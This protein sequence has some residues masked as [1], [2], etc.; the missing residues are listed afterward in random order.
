MITQAPHL[1]TAF[2]AGVLSFLTPC[3][4]PLVPGY[5]SFI[6]GQ[7]LKDM[8]SH[9]HKRE[10]LYPVMV[11]TLSF[12]LGFSLVFVSLGAAATSLGHYLAAYKPLLAQIGGAIILVLGLHML[13]VFRI[14]FLYREARFQGG[15][16]AGGALRA[17]LLGLAFAFGWTPCVGPILGTILTLAVREDTVG[18]GIWLLSAY[19]L[20]L[21]VPF[22]LTG[23][24]VNHFFTL[25]ERIKNHFHKIE[26]AAGVFLVLMGL[27]MVL[28]EFHT[29]KLLFQRLV[30]EFPQR[31]G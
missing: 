6:S 14:P 5:L 16:Q 24:A 19:S 22:F 12:I 10:T 15:S 26:I 3:V 23:L 7:S 31:W 11:T 9:E 20:G 25:F 21:G 18:Q 30:P 4:L 17:F 28:G 13:G 2:I 27:V 1:L 29:V 8:R